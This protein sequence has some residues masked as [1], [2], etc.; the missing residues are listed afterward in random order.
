MSAPRPLS[1]VPFSSSYPVTVSPVDRICTRNA[2]ASVVILLAAQFNDFVRNNLNYRPLD[3]PKFPKCANERFWPWPQS[4]V[5]FEHPL[6]KA[7]G[8]RGSCL[9]AVEQ[10]HISCRNERNSATKNR[11]AASTTKQAFL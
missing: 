9:S 5:A 11:R 10:S 6:R 4:V 7:S 2:N 8:T 1:G 3:L